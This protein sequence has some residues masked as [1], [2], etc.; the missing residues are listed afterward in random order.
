M[1]TPDEI[2]KAFDDGT[3]LRWRD[4]RVVITA[5]EGDQFADGDAQT[6]LEVTSVTVKVDGRGKEFDVSPSELSL[7]H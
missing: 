5:Y 2:Q 4:Q 3:L 7:E 1:L 6:P